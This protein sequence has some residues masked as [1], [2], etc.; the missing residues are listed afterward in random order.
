MLDVVAVQRDYAH[1][2]V[3]KSQQKLQAA[4]ADALHYEEEQKMSYLI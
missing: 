1:K 4:T 2:E 3:H